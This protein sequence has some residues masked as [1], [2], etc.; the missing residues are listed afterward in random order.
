MTDR[1][2]PGK[3]L[4]FITTCLALLVQSCQPAPAQR[5]VSGPNVEVQVERSVLSAPVQCTGS[6]SGKK[7]IFAT[8][9]R[10]REIRTYDS[11]GAGLA[12]G[13][14][15]GDGLL[16]I[17]FASIDGQSAILWNEGQLNFREEELDDSY[18]RAVTLVDVDGDGLLDITFTH[19]SLE[20]VSYWHN[21]GAGKSP[22]FVKAALDGVDH[23]AYA[24]AWADL[25]K[26]GTL[27]LVTGAYDVEL[28]NRGKTQD[29]IKATGGLMVY[30]QHEGKFTPRQ[31]TDRAETLSIALLDLNG[32]GRTD[33]WAANDFALRDTI[34]QNNP[35]GWQPVEP[36]RATSHS[37]M[38]IE[39]GDLDNNNKTM[40]FST[41]MNPGTISPEVLAVWLPV[42]KSLEEKHGP[43]DPQIMANVLQAPSGSGWRD[44]A[45]RRGVDA[46]GWSWSSKFGDLNNDGFLDLYVVNGM[47]ASNL[48][49]HLNNG[50]LVEENQ[51]FRNTG[52]GAF[53]S[54]PE[55]G[56]A[57]TASGRGMVMADMNNDGQLDIVTAN[58]RSQAELFEN[59]LCAG[60]G[61]E[62]ELAWNAPA[63]TRGTANTRALGARLA[64]R[65]S[66]GTFT[67]DVRS[68]SGYLSGEPPR[69]HFGFPADTELQE[70]IITYPD[71]A[72]ASIDA[73]E[74]QSLLKVT[75]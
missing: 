13:D 11:N 19:R 17:V 39:W 33:I 57:S 36:F 50:E 45:P 24:M 16:D 38:S 29:E 42:I 12:V 69:V 30:E 48:F 1:P 3:F 68:T 34:L 43:R 47:I 40:I 6:F 28:K 63:E 62:V 18:T 20:S 53:T 52:S 25:N 67:R 66:R 59:Q 9:T 14:L 73:P 27:D 60:Q 37:T 51:A 49:G 2:L 58:L 74:P 46:S 5:A 23:H 15:D 31:L 55:W 75:R 44:D 72:I 56:L 10:L 54:A 32:D 70:L 8:G 64:L 21:Q 7:L 65:T 22:R 4:L 61:L 35:D 71:G 41:D 26:D